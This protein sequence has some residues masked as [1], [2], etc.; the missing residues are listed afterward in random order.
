MTLYLHK[1]NFP[2][3]LS[4]NININI[5]KVCWELLTIPFPCSHGIQTGNL[6]DRLN[7]EE[8]SQ[9]LKLYPP[10]SLYSLFKKMNFLLFFNMGMVFLGCWVITTR[11]VWF[12]IPMA[13]GAP[14][15]KYFFLHLITDWVKILDVRCKKK[16]ISY[17][18]PPTCSAAGQN[19]LLVLY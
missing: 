16:T 8:V 14:F 7:S 2:P 12:S 19:S 4:N 17:L 3:N 5:R 15:S 13:I 10:S 1:S 18:A 11:A 6:T 9:E